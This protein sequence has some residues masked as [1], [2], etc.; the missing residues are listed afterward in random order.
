M[1][2]DNRLHN[3][4]TQTGSLLLGRVIRREKPRAFFWS[5]SFAGVRH[6]DANAG[7][8]F[9]S[10]KREC[11]A[12]GHRIQRI[13]HQILKCLVQQIG[14]AVDIREIFFQEVLRRNIGLADFVKLRFEQTNCASNRFVD[15]HPRKFGR[16]HL[17]KIAETVDDRV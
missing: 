4:Q 5:E 14:V 2:T 10:A 6:L 15:V 1:I 13:Q 16:W 3:G 9:R 8:N 12:R 11:T 7:L 17:G